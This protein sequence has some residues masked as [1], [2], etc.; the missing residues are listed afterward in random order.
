MRL[1][2]FDEI[3]GFSTPETSSGDRRVHSFGWVAVALSL[4]LGIGVTRLLSSGVA[5]FKARGRVRLDWVPLT[6]ASCIFV[7]QLQY[8][9]AIGELQGL[10]ATWTIVH[11]LI[12]LTLALLLFLA[13]ALVLPSAEL[14]SDI[15]VAG[16]FERDGRWALTC[17]SAY[18]WFSLF[19]NWHF[20]KASPISVGGAINVALAA[21]PLAFL[22]SDS[23]RVRAM[24]TV[25]Y[26]PL[27]LWAAWRA[28]PW[29]Y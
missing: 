13:A 12:L 28:S 20:W 17:L 2:P 26:V 25:G 4:V 29:S 24:I 8:W 1:I 22:R 9:W 14:V 5:V 10:I 18:F 6:W 15:G 3:G 11:F 16:A 21:A 19:A 27:S 7:W 23:R